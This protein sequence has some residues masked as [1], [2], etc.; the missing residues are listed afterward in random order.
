MQIITQI[1]QIFLI[2]FFFL[3]LILFLVV[4]FWLIIFLFTILTFFTFF[5]LWSFGLIYFLITLFYF[6]RNFCF[7]SRL[8]QYRVFKLINIYNHKHTINFTPVNNYI[9]LFILCP[10]HI[11]L[12]QKIK[13]YTCI[14]AQISIHI[15][16]LK[17]I[18]RNIIFL[19]ESKC[20]YKFI[21][22]FLFVEMVGSC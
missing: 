22:I 8:L 13:I 2:N 20:N 7:I 17:I 9:F 19:I 18:E 21:I 16:N 14:I 5:F 4:N 10:R 15:L 1:L 12:R 11:L 3:T 6:T